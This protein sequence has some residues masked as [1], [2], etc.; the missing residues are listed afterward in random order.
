MCP[1]LWQPR[2]SKLSLLQEI[3]GLPKAAWVVSEKREVGR[4][5]WPFACC[6]GGLADGVYRRAFNQ[7]SPVELIQFTQSL[8]QGLNSLVLDP[9]VKSPLEL[10]PQWSYHSWQVCSKALSNAN[11]TQPGLSPTIN[12]T[13]NKVLADHYTSG[14]QFVPYTSSNPANRFLGLFQAPAPVRPS[15]SGTQQVTS[16]PTNLL[17]DQQAPR[18]VGVPGHPNIA[19]PAAHSTQ[20]HVKMIEIKQTAPGTDSVPE[21]TPNSAR[22]TPRVK[23]YVPEVGMEISGNNSVTVIRGGKATTFQTFDSTQPL[24]PSQ[25]AP[26]ITNTTPSSS[27]YTMVISE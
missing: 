25:K 17:G 15:L 2:L 8:H 19:Q 7:A 1:L 16:T 4:P 20:A 26:P 18:Q 22:R 5:P 12:I 9:S 23:W 11:N 24:H 3:A 6:L 10:G 27:V 13:L 21:H 14:K